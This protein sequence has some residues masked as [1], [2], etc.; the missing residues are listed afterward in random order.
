MASNRSSTTPPSGMW[1][2]V[3]EALC[4]EFGERES[5]SFDK[6]FTIEVRD[7]ESLEKKAQTELEIL[8][9]RLAPLGKGDQKI[10]A[11]AHFQVEFKELI[12]F[13]RSADV[14]FTLTV[15]PESNTPNPP[16]VPGAEK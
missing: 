9:R 3:L 5:Q 6:F 7:G 4:R 13:G 10:G 16:R 8:A 12:T 2:S 15:L 11:D 14:W 1:S